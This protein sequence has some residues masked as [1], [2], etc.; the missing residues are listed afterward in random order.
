MPHLTKE[1]GNS[2]CL[3]SV[4]RSVSGCLGDES[5]TEDKRPV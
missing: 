2:I 1:R 3:N 4:E 5:R